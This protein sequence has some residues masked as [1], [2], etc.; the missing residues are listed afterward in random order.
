MCSTDYQ[1]C[2][3]LVNVSRSDRNVSLLYVFTSGGGSVLQ[4]VYTWE[5]AVVAGPVSHT[6]THH[7]L[8]HLS[9]I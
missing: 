4:P 2:E 7:F 8:L 3:L 1:N 6:S 9:L 5:H